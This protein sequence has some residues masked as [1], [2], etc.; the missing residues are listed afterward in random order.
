MTSI[1]LLT[2]LVASCRG[3]EFSSSPRNFSIELMYFTHLDHFVISPICVWNVLTCAYLGAYGNT[4]K[5]I[6]RAAIL[7]KNKTYLFKHVSKLTSTLFWPESEGVDVASATFLF[8]DKDTSVSLSYKAAISRLMESTFNNIF[9]FK[10]TQTTNLANRVIHSI[11]PTISNVFNA[12]DFTNTSLI[13][14]NVIYFSGILSTPFN[15]TYTTEEIIY[16]EKN[17]PIGSISMMHQKGNLRYSNFESMK[18]HIL[19]LPYGEQGKYS[20]LVIFPYSGIKPLDVYTKLDK[21]FLRDI[22]TKLEKDFNDFGTREVEVTIPRFR[23]RGSYHLNKPLSDMGMFDTFD[24]VLGQ[25]E[26]VSLDKLYIH[27]IEQRAE[28]IFTEAETVAFATIP[29]YYEQQSSFNVEA[30]QPFIFFLMEKPTA[31]IIFG[32]TY[33]KH[34]YLNELNPLKY[35]E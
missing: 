16:N 1:I 9:D 14:S 33:S 8:Q 32:G 31:T 27:S 23:M 2:F 25:F 17:E 5:E 6:Q 26:G 19:E 35:P 21:I 7:P 29:G 11:F 13:I 4:E 30:Q 20:M 15:S 22:F 3:V 28:L 34:R 24:P 10:D 12:D 18:S